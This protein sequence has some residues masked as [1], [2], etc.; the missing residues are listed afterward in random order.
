MTTVYLLILILF[1]GPQ[2]KSGQMVEFSTEADCIA[3]RVQMQ[4]A[5][6]AKALDLYTSCVAVSHKPKPVIGAGGRT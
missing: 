2:V 3:A 5:A 1:S 4:E 6:K